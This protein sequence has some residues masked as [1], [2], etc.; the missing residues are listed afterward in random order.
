MRPVTARSLAVC[1]IYAPTAAVDRLFLGFRRSIISNLPSVDYLTGPQP[2]SMIAAQIKQCQDPFRILSWRDVNAPDPPRSSLSDMFTLKVVWPLEGPLLC[3]NINHG[4]GM[5]QRAG[6]VRVD[7]RGHRDTSLCIDP[8]IQPQTPKK[9][10]H[11]EGYW[12][13]TAHL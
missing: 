11:V 5:W 1:V 13:L 2:W 8:A 3:L 6:H 9:Q 4:N 7:V 12:M 10:M